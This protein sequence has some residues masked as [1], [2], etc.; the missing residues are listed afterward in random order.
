MD[1]RSFYEKDY[2]G[3]LLGSAEGWNPR[4][5]LEAPEVFSD[6]LVEDWLGFHYDRGLAF[7]SDGSPIMCAFNGVAFRTGGNGQGTRIL[8]IH[9]VENLYPMAKLLQEIHGKSRSD[10]DGFLERYLDLGFC[11]SGSGNFLRIDGGFTT[12][13]SDFVGIVDVSA[14]GLAPSVNIMFLCSAIRGD[15]I[16]VKHLQFEQYILNVPRCP[17][18]FEKL[19]GTSPGSNKRKAGLRESRELVVP[20]QRVAGA[21]VSISEERVGIRPVVRESDLEAWRSYLGVDHTPV[22]SDIRCLGYLDEQE[23]VKAFEAGLFA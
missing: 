2:L 13:Y 17:G 12:P 5:D 6:Q 15:P 11:P 20:S 7:S 18:L 1:I 21:R 9:G 19:E 4:I 3:D 23:E 16:D 22:Q 10:I 8:A 14:S